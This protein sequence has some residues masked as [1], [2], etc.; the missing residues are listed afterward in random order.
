MRCGVR[1]LKVLDVHGTSRL[2]GGAF[3]HDGWSGGGG[4]VGQF[5]LFLDLM[6]VLFCLELDLQIGFDQSL[7]SLELGLGGRVLDQ[8]GDL[9]AVGHGRVAVELGG[10]GMGL[11]AVAALPRL[12]VLAQVGRHRGHVL[13]LVATSRLPDL[14][15]VVGTQ[16]DPL[17][18]PHRHPDVLGQVHFGDGGCFGGG[19][20]LQG[21]LLPQDVLGAVDDLLQG[22]LF[23]EMDTLFGSVKTGTQV[24]ADLAFEQ[25]RSYL[26]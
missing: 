1:V 19:W 18:T 9:V 8:V 24:A 6:M 13:G 2:R 17:G 7:E 22:V 20:L 16:L 14:Q 4:I 21:R 23:V 5:G 3:S 26:K 11:A 12:S 25:T 15:D 10:V